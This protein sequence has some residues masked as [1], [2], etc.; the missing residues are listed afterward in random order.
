[1]T[2][3]DFFFLFCGDNVNLKR[4]SSEKSISICNL[5]QRDHQRTPFPLK[6]ES[7][8][9]ITNDKTFTIKNQLGYVQGFEV[10]PSTITIHNLHLD[11]QEIK[12]FFAC[13]D[14][15]SEKLTR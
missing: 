6:M 11:L 9:Y 3:K 1:M 10:R 5:L 8:S 2:M 15:L 4:R 13:F 12:A 7:C 14:V